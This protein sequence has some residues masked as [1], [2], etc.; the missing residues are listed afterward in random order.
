MKP[1]S[2]SYHSSDRRGFSPQVQTLPGLLFARKI[3]GEVLV[4]FATAE[5]I[6]QTREGKVHAHPGDAVLT[7]MKGE[8]WR[9]SRGKFAEKYRPID[10][11]RAGQDGRYATLPVRVAAVHMKEAFE[12]ILADGISVLTGAP[13]DWL[14]D[15]GDGSLGII[16]P[17]IFAA[18]YRIGD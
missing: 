11:T 17:E 1:A 4:A 8:H 16:A 13:G 18:T 2:R 3:P 15:Y 6:V 12:V 7:G 9:V 14:V 10:P 5:C